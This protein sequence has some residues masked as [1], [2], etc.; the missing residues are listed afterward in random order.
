M[1]QQA[2]HSLGHRRG[3]VSGGEDGVDEGL[4][5]SPFLVCTMVAETRS[6]SGSTECRAEE[7]RSTASRSS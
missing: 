4:I 3:G 5:L 7:R 2:W 1:R 6:G